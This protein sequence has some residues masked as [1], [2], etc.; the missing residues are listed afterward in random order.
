MRYR[1]TAAASGKGRGPA[2]GRGLAGGRG[3]AG[4]YRH[5][6]STGPV[7][8]VPAGTSAPRSLGTG[9]SARRW[10]EGKAGMAPPQGVSVR[11]RDIAGAKGLDARGAVACPE[12]YSR[13]VTF[14]AQP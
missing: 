1:R 3:S 14:S 9:R 6:G 2:G 11:W 12:L 13:P 8:A 7:A 10:S 5:V 4:R